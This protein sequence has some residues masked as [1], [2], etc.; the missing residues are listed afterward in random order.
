MTAAGGRPLAFTFTGLVIGSVIYSLPFVVQ[1]IR[2]AFAATGHAPLE[3]AATLGASPRDRFFTVA[4]CRTNDPLR[5]FRHMAWIQ[6]FQS[7][8]ESGTLKVKSARP[9]SYRALIDQA[10]EATGQ[11]FAGCQRPWSMPELV[12]S[13][14]RGKPVSKRDG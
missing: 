7:V 2:D 5:R 3:A 6:T 13:A 4:V 11:R 14:R 9:D 12:R 10:S 1:P 8:T